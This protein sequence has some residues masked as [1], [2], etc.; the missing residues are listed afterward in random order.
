MTDDPAELTKLARKSAAYQ[1]HNRLETLGNILFVFHKNFLILEKNIQ[2]FESGTDSGIWEVSKRHLLDA[3]LLEITRM[4]HNYLA[5]AKTYVDHT[6]LVIRAWYRE[7]EFYPDYTR[8]IEQ[9]FTENPVSSFIQHLRNYSLH[10]SLPLSGASWTYNLDPETQ[11]P[12]LITEAFLY[13]EDLLIWDGW[14]KLSKSY[15]EEAGDRIN[16]LRVSRDYTTSILDFHEW[17]HSR[18]SSLH[19]EELRWLYDIQRRIDLALGKI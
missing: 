6:R 19:A 13:T 7:S 11:D 12:T 18:L 2:W 9:R 1:Y 3:A 10:Y 14:K 5:S 8:E 15:L 4:F 17:L 16:I